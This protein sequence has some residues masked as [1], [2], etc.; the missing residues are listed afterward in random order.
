L[1]ILRPREPVRTA[2]LAC[3]HGVP[4]SCGPCREPARCFG[5]DA[6]WLAAGVVALLWIIVGW[7]G[8]TWYRRGV[9]RCEVELSSGGGD[10]FL[11]AGQ[12]G[13]RAGVRPGRAVQV[14]GARPQPGVADGRDFGRVHQRLA[15][16]V[17]QAEHACHGGE[18]P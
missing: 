13:Q 14:Q 17:E 11:L 8:T 12:Q 5:N 15:D 10:A 7:R 6:G 2:V 18:L 9:P 16:E 1:G 3:L 4:D